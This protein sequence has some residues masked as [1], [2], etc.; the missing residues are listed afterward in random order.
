MSTSFCEKTVQNQYLN[1]PIL[2]VHIVWWIY[3]RLNVY[4][5]I[6]IYTNIINTYKC[7]FEVLQ[8]SRSALEDNNLKKKRKMLTVRLIVWKFKGL[9]QISL[10]KGWNKEPLVYLPERNR[11][12]SK[13]CNPTILLGR[14]GIN[15]LDFI[16]KLKA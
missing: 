5:S 4:T 3:W 10:K 12:C 6:L 1:G 11:Y 8:C 13:I 14:H 2:R 15:I 16:Y 9:P 7:I